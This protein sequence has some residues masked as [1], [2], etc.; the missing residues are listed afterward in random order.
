MN[1][2][3][4]ADKCRLE[5]IMFKRSLTCVIMLL[6][7]VILLTVSVSAEEA[8]YSGAVFNV[9]GFD[10]PNAVNDENK[11]TSYAEATHGTPKITVSREDGIGSI[12]VIFDK[13]PSGWTLTDEENE[14][15]VK[16][17]T[18]G[19]LHE[20]VDVS[21]L[22]GKDV[23]EL[24]M[25]FDIGTVITEIY[26]FSPGETPDWVQ[27]WEAPCEKADLMLLASHSDDEQLYF[28][29]VLPYYAVERQMN[30][31]VVYLVSHFDTHERPH[32]QLDGLWTV[33]VRNYPVIS[34]FPDLYSKSEDREVA[35][36]SALQIYGEQGYTFES[37][38]EFIT[39]CI[40][41]F[42]P[43]VVVS[44]DPN[45]EYGHGTHVVCSD[46]VVEA[47]KQG[48]NASFH[49]ESIDKYGAW[50]PDKLYLHLYPENQ[51]KFDWDKPYESLGGRTPY[52]VTR[53]GFQCHKTQLWAFN[54]WLCGTTSAPIT[55]AS[56]IT[57]YS[58]CIYGL[59]HTTVGLDKG[60]GDFFENTKTHEEKLHDEETQT[61][62][63]LAPVVTLPSEIVPDVQTTGEAQTEA[64]AD[65]AEPKDFNRSAAILAVVLVSIGICVVIV[66]VTVASSKTSVRMRKRKKAE[67]RNRRY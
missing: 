1:S 28:A 34:S 21:S 56:E 63:T 53:E 65:K 10:N 52:E 12:Y 61:Q 49:T 35:K 67:R 25:T 22:I 9:K 66:I 47:V 45:G 6:L 48:M 11:V 54:E 27:K 42:K 29:G 36:A 26:V 15:T 18:N 60:G 57:L 33:G 7:A 8:V 58:P 24:T 62:A 5:Y 17:G 3:G 30:V 41:R 40:R 2:V 51:I 13:I 20:Y 38:V 14:K 43:I 23:S 64:T 50:I 19:F 32:E 16:C 55:K 59:A 39:E 31:Q 46:A 44:H 4:N 37:F